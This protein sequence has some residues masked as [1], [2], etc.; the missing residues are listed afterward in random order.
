MDYV[1]LI[2]TRGPLWDE[3]ERRLGRARESPRTVRYDDLESL[4][5]LYRQILHDHAMV[6]DRYAETGVARRL[7]SLALQ[8]T[9]WL[10]GGGSEKRLGFGRFWSTSFPLAFRAQLPYLGIAAALFMASV[11]F[12]LSLGIA[13]PGV[14]LSLLGPQAVAGLR[15]GRLWTESLVTTVPPAVA[16]SGI[17]TNNMAVAL[18]GWAGGALAGVGS[19]Y[20]ILMNGFLLGAIVAATLHF[21]LEG[22]LME[23]VAAHGPLEITLIL[24]TAAAGLALGRAMVAAEDRPRREVLADASRGAL[25][26][27]G[28][29]LPWFLVLGVVEAFISPSPTIPTPLKVALGAALETLFL[30]M[31]FNP[32]LSKGKGLA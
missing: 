32:F 26:I 20:V 28:G 15:E 19:L 2:N 10:Q 27:L 24:S 7:R 9:H 22:R 31:A 17:A 8:G 12:G 5:L 3:F 16:S 25:V 6:S 18:T 21:S 1:R 30:L 4:A 23:F 13:E 29:C 11:L 14:G